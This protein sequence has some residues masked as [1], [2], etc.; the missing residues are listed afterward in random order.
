MFGSILQIHTYPLPL[1]KT[2]AKKLLVA[3]DECQRQVDL[4]DEVTVGLS[5]EVRAEWTG[6]VT[7]WEK[8]KSKPNPYLLDKSGTPVVDLFYASIV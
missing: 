5:E 6:A 3:N 7:D 4:F 8:D 2:L 1:G